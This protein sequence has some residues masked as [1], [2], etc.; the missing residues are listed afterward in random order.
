MTGGAVSTTEFQRNEVHAAKVRK[1]K[2]QSIVILVFKT[3]VS[4]ILGGGG[5]RKESTTTLTDIRT[6]KVWN[7]HDE[8]RGGILREHSSPYSTK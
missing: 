2:E 8:V 4:T 1:T 7:F 3:Y 5:E 6:S